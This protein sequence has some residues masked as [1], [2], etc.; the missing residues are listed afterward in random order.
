MQPLVISIPGDF[1]DIQIYRGRLYLWSYD[2]RLSVHDWD[3]LIELAY[4]NAS[5]SLLIKAAWL[6]GSTLY[7]SDI[8]SVMEDPA[9]EECFKLE[10]DKFAGSTAIVTHKILRN[11]KFCT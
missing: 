1:W 5:Q 9:F 4:P 6:R 3:R 10:Y 8:R 7:N 2:G 11:Y